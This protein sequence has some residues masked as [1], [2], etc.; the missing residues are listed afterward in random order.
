VASEDDGRTLL[1]CRILDDDAY[2]RQ[3]DNIITWCEPGPLP[4][5]GGGV[6]LALS[7]QEN[8]GCLEIWGQICDVQGKYR[9]DYG[10]D[11]AQSCPLIGSLPDP[12]LENLGEIVEKLNGA[13]AP[14]R[15]A[16]ANFVST[17]E[18]QYI[19]K[20]LQVFDDCEDL[21]DS[22]GLHKL[23]ALF[24]SLICLNEG[25]L[26]EVLLSDVFFVRVA[27]VFEYDPELKERAHHREWFAK[28]V[29]FKQVLPMEDPEV[30]AKIHQNFRVSF[31]KD[32][33]LRPMM[34]DAV[35]GTLNSVTFYNNAEI[36]LALYQGSDYLKRIFQL[37]QSFATPVAG[38]EAEVTEKPYVGPE[39]ETK[40]DGPQP[41]APPR[42]SRVEVLMF[43]REM[44]LM[45]K[46]LQLTS[47]DALYRY[48]WSDVPFFDS[49]TP[50]LADKNTT[51][52]EC[53]TVME[54][55]LHSL[56]HDPS[57]LRSHVMQRA[58]HPP[59]PPHMAG[60]GAPS[61]E[62]GSPPACVAA[63][64][65][66]KCHSLLFWVIRRL[67]SGTEDRG[68]LVHAS[69]ICRM[70]LDVDTMEVQPDRD[71]FLGVFY[72]HY[73]H[74]LVAPFWEDLEGQQDKSLSRA[75]PEI[76]RAVRG[77]ACDLLS[78]CVHSHTYR[79]KYFVLRNNVVS[80]VLQLLK[81]K[82]KCL[83]L[84]AIRFL[85]RC[86]GVK[87]E[88][89]NR[90]I[91]KNNL[92]APV[93]ALLSQNM[94]RDNLITSAVVEMVEFVRAE[95]IKSLTEYIVER[96]SDSFAGFT[97]VPTFR[98]IV[99]KHDQNKDYAE[100]RERELVSPGLGEVNAD[101]RGA[102]GNIS[103]SRLA[104]QNR[105]RL[106]EED[107][108][109]AYFNGSDE[110]E[111]EAENPALDKGKSE[112]E[113]PPGPLPLV[114]YADDEEDEEEWQHRLKNG[115]QRRKPPGSAGGGLTM[116]VRLKSGPIDDLTSA[117]AADAPAAAGTAVES[118]GNS[119]GVNSSLD[120]SPVTPSPNTNGDASK[121]GAEATGDRTADQDQEPTAGG[122][123]AATYPA[124]APA[125][126]DA[127]GEEA[128]NS[129]PQ[130]ANDAES[131]TLPLRRKADESASTA[132][133][134]DPTEVKR[135]RSE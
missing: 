110:D 126:E 120:P 72:D 80:Q 6:D 74:W 133:G 109:E 107:E 69:E 66:E 30:T 19:S 99:S 29:S 122:E 13:S 118:L 128:T 61:A 87:D 82:E 38:T 125:A 26:L 51:R 116:Q 89:Y 32:V 71:S 67:T 18:G 68:I 41:A 92:L 12:T 35:I 106:L 58:S 98:S 91:V 16:L 130:L 104:A 84:A 2:Q 96:F 77:H 132:E 65:P 56:Q 75:S 39:P 97:F 33:L 11:R 21:E 95:N 54:I 93:F 15:E 113:P 101:S 105:R 127:G 86:I 27:G 9:M 8:Q 24:K 22:E 64:T 28:T 44:F 85:R 20:L 52:A 23:C 94:G 40:L 5:S 83:Q 117:P 63:A 62:P 50:V 1:Q 121:G 49:L 25:H 47:R 73:I 42:A 3:G 59:L 115:G 53:S 134:D 60:V 90:Y 55:I 45:A 79:M 88:F 48:L 31:L 34:D 76:V 111:V 81:Y 102:V 17:N 100:S 129:V 131:S 10:D 119:H 123:P 78:F 108:D 7:F 57:L 124:P 135:S 112:E 4:V 114:S 36:I 14:S 46:T 37:L 43:L 103:G 70:V